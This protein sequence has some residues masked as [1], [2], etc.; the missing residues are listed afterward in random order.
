[1]RYVIAVDQIKGD[2]FRSFVRAGREFTNDVFEA[3]KLC[4]E[5]SEA[6]VFI[7]KSGLKMAINVAKEA[8]KLWTGSGV[9][10]Y[11]NYGQENEA[12][13]EIGNQGVIVSSSDWRN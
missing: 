4:N 6:R 12:Y 11:R 8:T 5:Y 13:L 2:M 9:Y 7:G 3:S 1:M 10:V